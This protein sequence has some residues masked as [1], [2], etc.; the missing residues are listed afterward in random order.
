MTNR[1]VTRILDH[2]CELGECPVWDELRRRLVWVD[3][4]QGN[5]HEWYVDDQSHVVTKFPIKIGSFALTDSSL[6]IAASSIGFVTL[7]LVG[8]RVV[9]LDDPEHDLPNNRF[10]DGKCDPKGRFW[11]GTMDEVNGV[12]GAGALYRL[13]PNGKSAKEIPNV[14][15]SNGLVWSQDSKT[16]YYIDSYDQNVK[17]YDY[18]LAE[19]KI[20]NGR[21]VIEIPREDGIPDGMTSDGEGMLWIALWG[22]GKVV[23]Y[24]PRYGRKLDEISLPVSQVTSCVF[25]GANFNDLFITTASVGLS[26]EE[27]LTQPHAG[28]LFM[29]R[30]VCNGGKPASRWQSER[31]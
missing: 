3:I 28:S 18:D 15:C 26:K 11:A 8:N 13:D 23:R 6:L 27:I 20:A 5:I 31:S 19:G 4:L 10:N 22:G 24:D 25:G 30:N 1:T 2:K 9:A 14:T 21:T 16:M 7:D 29:A 17:A 12:Q